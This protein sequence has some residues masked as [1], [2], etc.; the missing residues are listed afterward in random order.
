MSTD[1]LFFPKLKRRKQYKTKKNGQY[2][3]Y[4]AYKQEI[5]EDCLGHCVY[6]DCHENEIGGSDSMQLDHFR[7][8][9]Y[10]E[11]RH[12]LN[13]PYNLHW[14]CAGCNGLKSDHWPARGT[15]DTIVGQEGF[16]DPFSE[17][18]RNYFEVRSNGELVALNPPAT[19]MITLL[20]LNRATRKRVRERRYQTQEQL[21]I[22][23][24]K[25]AE[26]EQ[27]TNL[28]DEQEKVMKSNL[29]AF[30]NLRSHLQKRLDFT[31]H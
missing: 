18:R 6:C 14:S 23:E 21:Q 17:D 31:L 12:L 26:I 25:I 10:K 28:T 1:S 3:V 5:R 13:D 2:Y 29:E 22:I 11:Y 15:D 30:I 20:V 24:Y 27:L 19:Y 8:Q 4:G 9:K 7:P 16:I